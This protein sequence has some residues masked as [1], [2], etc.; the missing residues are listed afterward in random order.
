MKILVVDDSTIN[1]I[2]LQNFLEENGFEVVSV[3][4]GLDAIDILT[5]EHIDLILLDVMMP[6][7]S[8]FDF[9]NHL[10]NKKISIPV[11]VITAN[12]DSGNRERAFKLGAKAYITK[13]IQFNILLDKIKK[14]KQLV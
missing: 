11:I 9:L 7:F 8:G 12:T 1:N 13:P 5:K 2:L 10:K 3:L 4:S 6:D 14:S